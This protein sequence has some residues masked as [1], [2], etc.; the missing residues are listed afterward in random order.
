MLFT[1]GIDSFFW[2]SYT[3]ITPFKTPIIGEYGITW[4][5]FAAFH[6]NVL[7]GKSV[8]WGATPWH[9]YI[10][11]AIPKLLG[12]PLSIMILIPTALSV[13]PF[14]SIAVE[15]LVPIIGFVASFSQLAH[16][17][18]RFIMYIIPNLTL[19][20]AIGAHTIFARRGT[21]GLFAIATLLLIASVIATY[22]SSA[23]MLFISSL[24]YPG[25]NAVD[26]L[27]SLLP[28]KTPV[29]VHLNVETC[30]T[31]ASRF[32]QDAP[33]KP[34]IGRRE[35]KGEFWVWS[36]QEDPKVLKDPMFWGGVDW[37]VSSAGQK[38]KLGSWSRVTGVLAFAGVKLY[39]PGDKVPSMKPLLGDQVG[40]VVD[41]VQDIVRGMSGGWTAGANFT[42]ILTVYKKG[43]E[44]Q[45]QTA[46]KK[47]PEEIN[48]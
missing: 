37:A 1:V 40:G 6:F 25:G 29:V 3:S 36:K 23:G 43:T 26:Q 19:I 27:H 24:N 9:Y 47:G 32:V 17:E 41:S 44:E 33:I 42:E 8:E 34:L 30:M 35:Q 28:H 14:S 31:G 13:S 4:P 39:R 12:N 15:M 21:H 45:V 22:I 10:T 20:S 16:K 48:W 38:P 11:S 5:E 46:I 18:W 7:Q 2:Q